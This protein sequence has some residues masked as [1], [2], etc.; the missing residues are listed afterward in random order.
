VMHQE[1]FLRKPAPAG[2][3]KRQRERRERE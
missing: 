3:T 2:E 1:P